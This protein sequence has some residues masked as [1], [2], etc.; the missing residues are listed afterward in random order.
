MSGS[1]AARWRAQDVV[2]THEKRKLVDQVGDEAEEMDD[3]G[4]EEGSHRARGRTNM[5]RDRH[6]GY[7]P[8]YWRAYGVVAIVQSVLSITLEHR[9]QCQTRHVDIVASTE[10]HR[11]MVFTLSCSC[12]A[13]SGA[14]IELACACVVRD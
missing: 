1:E 8:S 14:D 6:G 3:S 9:R 10:C 4:D 2:Y 5:K 7:Q 13:M 11:T 12:H